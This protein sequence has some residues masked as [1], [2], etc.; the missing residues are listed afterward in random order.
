M[1]GRLQRTVGKM[2][3]LTGLDYE[4]CEQVLHATSVRTLGL[5]DIAEIAGASACT[6][7]Q[8]RRIISTVTSEL[9]VSIDRPHRDLTLKWE[10]SKRYVDKNKKRRSYDARIRIVLKIWKGMTKRSA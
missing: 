8:V 4:V 2:S 9:R 7:S 5:D 1:S 3:T 10:N 6:K